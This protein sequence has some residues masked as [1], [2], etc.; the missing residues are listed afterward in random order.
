MMQVRTIPYIRIFAGLLMGEVSSFIITL[1]S[2]D[3]KEFMEYHK[4]EKIRNFVKRIL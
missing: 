3:L 2:P 1:D 4:E